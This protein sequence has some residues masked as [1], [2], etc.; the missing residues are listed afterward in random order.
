MARRDSGGSFREVR[1]IL[2]GLAAIAA[3][4]WYI[5]IPLFSW[6]EGGTRDYIGMFSVILA[7]ISAI[8]PPVVAEG[9]VNYFFR[10]GNDDE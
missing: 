1:F 2:V 6:V 3:S 5:S 7:W 9:V 4:V 8:V 10:S